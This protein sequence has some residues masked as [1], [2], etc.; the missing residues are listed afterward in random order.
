MN[1][2]AIALAVAA[3]LATSAA[4]QA[5]TILYG[6]AR[7]SVDYQKADVLRF[8]EP[9]DVLDVFD[10]GVWD[11]INHSSRLG[12]RGSEDLGDGLSAIYQ[13]EFG[14]D[15]A[16]GGNFESNR[17]RL[18]G[19]RGENFG[20]ISIGTQ[21]TPYYNVAGVGDVFNSRWFSRGTTYLGD[22]RRSN[23]LFYQTPNF[24]GFDGQA[25]LVMDGQ[26]FDELGNPVGEDAVDI[27]DVALRY[28]NGPIFAGAAYVSTEAEPTTDQYAVALGWTGEALAATFTFED[29]DFT[30]VDAQ[31]YYG[32]LSYAFGSNVV[33]V[34]YGFLDPDDD[35][36]ETHNY[37][38]GFQHNLS[39][40][41][42]LWVEYTGRN[43]DE[44]DEITDVNFSGDSDI[45]SVGMRHDF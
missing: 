5:E 43:Q 30:G 29:G 26:A 13:F 31:N 11:V 10:D 25:M 19:L 32:T 17:P 1:K 28:T 12:V 8:T 36:E 9:G 20:T 38:L 15:A 44:F 45:I 34:A 21:W 6:S 7:L 33:R 39:I 41:S 35:V 24:N 3:A 14:V 4:A 42:R 2:S 27:W 40:R 22:F 18:V 23:S 16:E 37:A